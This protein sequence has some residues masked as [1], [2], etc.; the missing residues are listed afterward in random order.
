MPHRLLRTVPLAALLALGAAAPALAAAPGGA[1]SFLRPG[2]RWAFT[3][4]SI[5][6]YDLYRQALERVQRHFHPEAPV[7]L[8]QGG[9]PGATTAA[10]Q[11]TAAQ[12][13]TVVSIMLGMNNYINSNVRFGAD[14]RPALDAY[15]TDMLAKV[16]ACRAAGA[17]VVLL[18]PTLTDERFEHGIFELRGGA[19]FLAECAGILREIAA[20]R[21]GVFYLPVQEEFEAFEQTLGRNQILRHDGV[22]PS[23][24]GQYQIARTLWRHL[25]LA[26]PMAGEKRTLAATPPAPVP[27]AVRPAARRLAEPGQGLE[28]VLTAAAPLRV[29][30]TW[31][32]G[33]H[34]GRDELDLAV[35]DTTWRPA[36]PAATLALKPGQMASLVFDLAAADGR[37]SLYLADLSCVPVVH[38]RDGVAEGTVTAEGPRP[39]GATVG[40]WRIERRGA[41]L[42]FSGEVRDGEI[43]SDGFW[44]WE[45]DGVNLYLDFRPAERFGDLSFDEDVHMAILTAHGA[46]AFGVTLIPWVGRGMHLAAESGGEATPTG[47]R[48]HLDVSRYFTKNSPVA[49]DQAEFVGFNLVIPDRDSGPGGAARTEYHRAYAPTPFVDK[50]PNLFLAVDLK[51][52]HPADTLVHV[53][54]F[55]P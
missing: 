34:R 53:H 19:R 24:L 45:R 3:G 7:T 8:L 26:G 23:A 16:E 32:L 18:S 20:G 36:I 22:H 17:Q 43:R 39:E 25:N 10:K 44:A 38:L 6:H 49:F 55:G 21:E 48:W 33:E 4:D 12:A 9:I 31:S 15:R 14:T 27:V 42:L 28:F 5:T 40:T 46:P 41:G 2:D 52:A 29:T 51:G 13:P 30:A 35:G 47:W 37:G 1:T 54:L 50:Y 11:D